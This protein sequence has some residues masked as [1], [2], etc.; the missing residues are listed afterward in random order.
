VADD[1][2]SSG[3]LRDALGISPPG[4]I[5]RCLVAMGDPGCT[6]PAPS[7]TASTAGDLAGHSLGN[8]VIAGLCAV[9]GD[10]LLALDE[11]G[12]LVG[13]D[14]AGRVLPATTTPW[15]S[16]RRRRT[17]PCGASWRWPP[18]RHRPHQAVSISPADAATPAAVI[19]AIAEADQVVLARARCSPACWPH[20]PGCHEGGAGG[21]HREPGLRL[22]PRPARAGD[23]RLRRAG[24][25][26]ALLDHGVEIDDVLCDPR[27]RPDDSARLP[28]PVHTRA[29]ARDD[30]RAHDPADWRRPSPICSDRVP[31]GGSCG[32]IATTTER[33]RHDRAGRH[34]R[35]SGASGA[36]SSGQR[37]QRAP[38]SRWWR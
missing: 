38:T 9:T 15:C 37:G 22:Q 7:S 4:D 13:A 24:H 6:W 25:V 14:K 36:T 5:R 3:R 28:V 33:N 19:E 29:V 11:A 10:F 20:S 31:G 32:S 12:R 1:G 34:Q 30:G 8:V 35:L 23:G 27:F 18:H 21:H 2:G 17:A 26:E 16:R